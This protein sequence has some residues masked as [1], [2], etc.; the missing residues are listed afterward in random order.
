MIY[1]DIYSKQFKHVICD[2]MIIQAPPIDEL[3]IYNMD[4]LS[5][6]ISL[7]I[8]LNSNKSRSGILD[9]FK[10]CTQFFPYFVNIFLTSC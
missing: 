6:F 3:Y 10:I 9:K 4:S 8:Q 1:M 2:M 7:S 5:L